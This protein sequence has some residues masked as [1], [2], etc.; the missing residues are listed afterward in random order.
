MDDVRIGNSLRVIRI[1]KHLR[2][3]D[4]GRRARVSR[5]IVGRIENGA[6]GRYPLDTARAVVGALGARLDSRLRYQGAELDRIVN[7]AHALL[8]ESV[9]GHLHRCPGWTW[10]PE[11]GFAH[12]G[13]RGVIDILAGHAETRSLLIIELKTELVDPQELV[14]VMHR[15]VR[16]GRTIAQQQGWDPL[17]VSAWVIVRDTAT[18]RRRLSRHAR[19]LR[20]AFPV[21]GRTARGWLMRPSSPISALSF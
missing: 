10:L 19:L 8:H 20:S 21:E 3:A 4:V 2:Q 17:T 14:A 16:L 15:R 18:E 12:Y 11:V 9:A 13:E 1:R 7:A 6:A 5:Q